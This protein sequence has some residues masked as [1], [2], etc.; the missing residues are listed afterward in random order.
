MR[1]RVVLIGLGFS[2]CL[3]CCLSAAEG[4]AAARKDPPAG[5]P[6][7]ATWEPLPD[8]TDEFEG[9]KLDPAKWHDHNPKWKGRQPGFF[10]RHNVTVSQGKLHITMRAEDLPNLPDGYHTFTCGAVK[11]TRTVL[12]GY[13]EARCKPMKSRGSSAFWFYNSQSDRW[14][15]IDVFEIGGGAPK[16][17]RTV[18]MNVHVFR[19]PDEK[20]HWAKPSQHRAPFDL[21][22]DYHVYGLEWD[23]DRITF[24]FDGVAVRTLENTHWHQPLHLNFDSETMP[25]WFGL[26]E[27]KDLPSTFSIEY[28]RAWKRV[29]KRATEPQGA[30]ASKGER[31]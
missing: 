6:L 7:H 13:F 21:A 17:E 14:T 3:A 31:K 25:N 20:R 2:F 23:K 24:Y 12:Y 26:P 19:T 9:T 10:A 27:K 15:E 4:E 29:G 1:P 16:H 22:D 28:I 5:P 11:S 18:H 30:P 8:F